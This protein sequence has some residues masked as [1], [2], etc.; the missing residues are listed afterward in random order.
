MR[1]KNSA[2]CAVIRSPIKSPSTSLLHIVGAENTGRTKRPRV[3]LVPAPSAAQARPSVAQVSS[4]MYANVG[5]PVP[6][7]ARPL[8]RCDS[9]G[10]EA[11]PPVVALCRLVSG[12]PC[13]NS[14]L[15]HS[16]VLDFC[17]KHTGE[18]VSSVRSPIN[19]E[20][21]QTGQDSRRRP[22]QVSRSQLPGVSR[23]QLP[24][25]LARRCYTRC[26][27]TPFAAPDPEFG[28]Q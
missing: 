12:S 6:G 15:K 19:E 5:S 26:G 11:F 13:P 18:A 28:T 9:P 2:S 23:S 1:R 16:R 3:L 10:R 22:S 17:P 7:S 25:V 20:H 27:A 14:S 8:P 4:L 24:G 21:R